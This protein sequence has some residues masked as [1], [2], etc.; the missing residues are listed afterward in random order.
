MNYS[1]LLPRSVD[2]DV[3]A[4]ILNPAYPKQSDRPLVLDLAQILW[5]RGEPDGVAAHMTDH[6]LPN[7]PKH[8]VLMQVAFGDHQVS[9]FQA[10]VEARTIGAR[11]HQPAF[12]P[13]RSPQK[14]PLWGIGALPSARTAARASCSGTRARAPSRAPPLTNA[15]AAHRARP[16]LVPALDARGARAEVAVPAGRRRRGRHLRRRAVRVGDVDAL[17]PRP[18]GCC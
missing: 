1:V 16:A 8:Q 10:E 11:V 18:C 13:G 17:R 6:P 14:N 12:T 4:K 3:Y 9:M 7:T 5:D 2:F 15:P